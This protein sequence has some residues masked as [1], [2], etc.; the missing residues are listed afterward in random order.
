MISNPRQKLVK[1]IQLYEK[2]IQT[3]SERD[4]KLIQAVN[5]LKEQLKSMDKTSIHKDEMASNIMDDYIT[6][7]DVFED[8]F[9][10]QKIKNKK[11]KTKVAEIK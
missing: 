10:G 8:S 11:I 6:K 4:E 5:D 3:Q 7:Q 1:A 2:L 9:Y